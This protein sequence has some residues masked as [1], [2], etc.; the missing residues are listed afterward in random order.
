MTWQQ[1]KIVDFGF[2]RLVPEKDAELK[3]ICGTPEFMA[4]EVLNFD[5]VCFKSDIWWV[6]KCKREFNFAGAERHKQAHET[7]RI[8]TFLKMGQTRPRF[9]YFCSFRNY[10]SICWLVN[11]KPALLCVP[12]AI[13]W[14]CKTYLS[15]TQRGREPWTSGCGR[16]LV[17]WMLWVRIPAPFIGWTFFHK[18]LL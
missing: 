18:N 17:C 12:N 16:R 11:L 14:Y 6:M 2:A 1:V 7:T 9:A 8:C 10:R 15:S 13:K 3:V 5:P 4:P